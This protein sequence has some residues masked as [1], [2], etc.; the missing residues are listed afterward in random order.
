[1]VATSDRRDA[2]GLAE[3]ANV[4]GDPPLRVLHVV[5]HFPPDRVGG[6]GEV[7]AHVHRALLRRGHDSQ[8]LT[9]GSTTDDPTVRRVCAGPGAGFARRSGSFAAWAGEFDLV[10]FHHG[11]AL[12]LLMGLRRRGTR[13]L[14]TLHV[15]NRSI[16]RSEL[17][18]RVDG[19]RIGSWS[20]AVRQGMV[21]G[22]AKVCLDLAAR[23][24]ADQ[25][26]FISSYGA[27]EICRTAEDR[28]VI[29]NGIVVPEAIE[30]ERAAGPSLLYV[31]TAGPRKRTA[32]LPGLM[33]RVRRHVPDARMTV[34]GFDPRTTPDMTAEISRLGLADAFE[35]AGTLRSD[36]LRPLYRAATALVVPSCY[37]GLPMVALE[38]MGH[39][40]PVVATRAG[41]IDEAVADGIHGRIVAVDDVDALAVAATELLLDRELARCMGIAGRARVEDEFD[42]ARQADDYLALYREMA[43]P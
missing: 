3:S 22:V 18:R 11:E 17:P 38:A 16:V 23:R 13:T 12:P 8:V 39:G 37:E 21:L 4:A 27:R 26:T 30:A 32:L 19:R 2:A 15:D 33:D 29:R 24:V 20:H 40:L 34:A 31:G 36:E 5:S 43:S 41:G 10:H 1:M 14:L 42:V 25:A 35:F 28:I 9:T 7:A 6:V